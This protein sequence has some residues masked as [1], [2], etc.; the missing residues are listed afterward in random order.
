MTPFRHRDRRFRYRD[1]SFRSDPKIGHAR[2][3]SPVTMKWNRRSRYRNDRSRW[4][5]IPTSH[6][7]STLAHAYPE[8]R[9]SS[10]TSQPAVLVWIRLAEIARQ[11]CRT[12]YQVN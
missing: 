1:R 9:E 3:E 4:T 6:D 10:I 12:L 5:G 8:G 11:T 7:L 2:S